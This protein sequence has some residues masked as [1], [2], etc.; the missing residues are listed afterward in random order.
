MWRSQTRAGAPRDVATTCITQ[1][2]LVAIAVERV[3][4][5]LPETEAKAFVAELAPKVLDV[6]PLVVPRATTRRLTADHAHPPVGVRARLHPTV[7]ARA[8]SDADAVVGPRRGAVPPGGAAPLPALR[9]APAPRERTRVRRRRPA[10]A[11]ARDPSRAP[12][13]RPRA[14]PARRPRGAGRRPRVQ[15]VLRRR[16]PVAPRADRRRRS[17]SAH[18]RAGRGARA[19]V[20]R[21]HA[22]VLLPPRGDPRTD[23][24]SDHRHLPATADDGNPRARARR[25]TAGSGGLLVGA[26]RCRASR[27]KPATSRTT[28]TGPAPPG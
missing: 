4:A 24:R 20:A 14:S 10:H 12:R 26:I 16:E 2:P 21:T 1:P 15:R 17:R 3:A 19:A 22:R 8:R 18:R 25:P 28:A 7:D 11:R 6:P 23:E 27:W 13:L 5:A 9:H